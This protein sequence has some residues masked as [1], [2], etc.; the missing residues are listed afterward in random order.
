MDSLCVFTQVSVAFFFFCALVLN[1]LGWELGSI[2][3]CPSV[4]FYKCSQ[5]GIKMAKL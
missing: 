3:I 4:M 5:P 2:Q 1:S